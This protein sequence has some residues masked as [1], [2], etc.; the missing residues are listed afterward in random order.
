[1]QLALAQPH[2]E[3][4]SARHCRA[5]LDVRLYRVEDQLCGAQVARGSTTQTTQAGRCCRLCYA[6]D[7]SRP[8]QSAAFA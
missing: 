1:M 5:A 8:S 3:L 4:C 7:G 6:N 2:G